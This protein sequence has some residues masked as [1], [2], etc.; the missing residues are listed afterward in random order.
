MLR[1]S[2]WH[3]VGVAAGTPVSSV[4]VLREEFD[5]SRRRRKRCCCASV[6]GSLLEL[7]DN[8]GEVGGWRLDLRF[9]VN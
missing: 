5:D 1:D 2:L 8:L 6:V 9:L 7:L 4:G 3:E